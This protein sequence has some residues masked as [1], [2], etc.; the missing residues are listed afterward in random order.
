MSFID[1]PDRGLKKFGLIG[2]I[3]PIFKG[4]GLSM[5]VSY[6]QLSS[7]IY[8]LLSSRTE[9]CL[10]SWD[11]LFVILMFKSLFSPEKS[12]SGYARFPILTLKWNISLVVAFVELVPY[13]GKYNTAPLR[14]ERIFFFVISGCWWRADNLFE[15][16]RSL[17]E[18]EP[19]IDG[20]LSAFYFK[21][22]PWYLTFL[23]L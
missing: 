11:P 12:R 15:C 9:S 17:E 19:E 14:G 21:S 5:S 20:L 10:R 18:S 6:L 7:R 2:L 13:G 1:L 16:V 3:A 4:L 8:K 23:S 22:T